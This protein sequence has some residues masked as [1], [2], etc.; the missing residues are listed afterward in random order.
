MTFILAAASPVGKSRRT[1]DV[2][3]H[4]ESFFVQY[5]SSAGLVLASRTRCV[6]FV[7]SPLRLTPPSRHIF[8]SLEQLP[9]NRTFYSINGSPRP[10]FS[11]RAGEA[12]WPPRARLRGQ[13]VSCTRGRRRPSVLRCF[14]RA[15]SWRVCT[16]ESQTQGAAAADVV[17]FSSSPNSS[18]TLVSSSVLP[19]KMEQK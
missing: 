4:S 9:L 7:P 12:I 11:L 8:F 3:K 15:C 16:S 5:S 6:Y 19:E 18:A 1:K 2:Y 10:G 14:M 17:C 13:H